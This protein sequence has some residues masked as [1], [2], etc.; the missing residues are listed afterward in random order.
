MPGLIRLTPMPSLLQSSRKDCANPLS[1][2][3]A[4]LYNA[5]LLPAVIADSDPI[6]AMRPDFC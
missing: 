5:P 4:L 3:L 1:P 2:N 6:K